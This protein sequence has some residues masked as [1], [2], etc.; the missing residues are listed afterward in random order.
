MKSKIL[1]VEVID[2]EKGNLCKASEET[3]FWA[4][5]RRPGAGVFRVFN[6]IYDFSIEQNELEDEIWI[7]QVMELIWIVN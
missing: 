1:L 2:F 6:E 4:Y 3:L 5:E 7:K